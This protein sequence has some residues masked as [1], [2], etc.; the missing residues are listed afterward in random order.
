MIWPHSERHPGEYLQRRFLDP[1][2]LSASDLARALD[3]PRS[4]I[5]EILSGKRGISADTALRLGRYLR[6]EPES[7][8]LLQGVW[9]LAQCEDS[10]ITPADTRGF[11]V[12]PAGATLL[13]ERP[14]APRPD[15]RMSDALLARLRASAAEAPEHEPRELVHVEYDG[16]QHAWVSEPR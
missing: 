8:L 1:L 2:G 10:A 3:V 11:L 7:W 5:S 16:G 14:P 9:D 15:A 4:R 13:P 6:M 12:G